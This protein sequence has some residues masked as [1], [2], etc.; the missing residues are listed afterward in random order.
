MTPNYDLEEAAERARKSYRDVTAKLGLLGFDTAIPEA[1]R[2]MAETSVAQTRQASDRSM[3]AFETSLATF[4]RSFHAAGQGAAAFNR[5]F[6]DPRPAQSEFQFRPGQ[7][8][9]RRQKP[10]RHGGIADGL[11]ARPVR[12]AFGPSRGSPRAFDQ[13]DRRHRRA[14]AGTHGAQ[15]R[16]GAQGELSSPVVQ[17]PTLWL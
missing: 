8:P 17:P 16:G 1:V 5:K 13:G 9:G 11:L 12:D 15:R 4:E 10:H 14:D 6:I 7:E 2:T 3:D